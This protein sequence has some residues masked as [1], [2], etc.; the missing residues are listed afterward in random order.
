ML[1]ISVSR[2]YDFSARSRHDLPSRCHFCGDCGFLST[3]QYL[4]GSRENDSVLNANVLAVDGGQVMDGLAESIGD[5][6]RKMA[7]FEALR[8]QG[9]Y[10]SVQCVGAPMIILESVQGG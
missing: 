7:A 5:G 9:V 4:L 2:N 3:G 8:T 1:K 10:L 6:G